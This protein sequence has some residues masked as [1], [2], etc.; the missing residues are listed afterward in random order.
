MPGYYIVNSVNQL[1]PFESDVCRS[2]LKVFND[3]HLVFIA[4][5]TLN[6]PDMLIQ[7][8]YDIFPVVGNGVATEEMLHPFLVGNPVSLWS[9]DKMNPHR[10]HLTRLLIMILLPNLQGE[11]VL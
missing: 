7:T 3:E 6:R 11:L 1:Q 8:N 4:L 10:P 2:L 5:F 9:G